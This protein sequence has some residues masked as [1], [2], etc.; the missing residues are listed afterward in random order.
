MQ[1]SFADCVQSWA[2]TWYHNILGP[3]LNALPGPLTP[4]QK[5]EHATKELRRKKDLIEELERERQKR[6]DDSRLIQMQIKA[7][8]AYVQMLNAGHPDA[9]ET[10]LRMNSTTIAQ[11][12]GDINTINSYIH[13]RNVRADELQ[14][15]MNE[16][17]KRM[18]ECS[19]RK[20]ALEAQLKKLNTG[21]KEKVL[22][23]RRYSP[24][25]KILKRTWKSEEAIEAALKDL[26]KNDLYF[27]SA[28]SGTINVSKYTGSIADMAVIQKG[29]RLIPAD[30]VERD[31]FIKT[32][33][34]G[35]YAAVVEGHGFTIDRE[36]RYV[37]NGHKIGYGFTL[38]FKE[39]QPLPWIKITFSIPNSAYNAVAIEDLESEIESYDETLR[40]LIS[41]NVASGLNKTKLEEGIQ[42]LQEKK[43]N[44]ENEI[45]LINSTPIEQQMMKWKQDLQK[46]IQEKRDKE[47]QLQ[48]FR[49]LD[50][51]IERLKAENTEEKKKLKMHQNDQRNLAII[52]ATHWESA[53]LLRKF[54]KIVLA[55]ENSYPGNGEAIKRCREFIE[56][57]DTHESSLLRQIKTEYGF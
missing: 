30:E 39:R 7:Q 24:N 45:A 15:A 31:R 47:T 57:F 9:A 22:F 48:D 49:E 1:N 14:C 51:Q 41:Y 53:R 43:A 40:G 20:E 18:V 21:T 16:N 25:E 52:I 11:K 55:P 23:E 50:Q 8:E 6:I 13:V 27:D 44:L 12:T 42:F 26:S 37:E 34:G 32:R 2:H 3:F 35:G 29:Y 10:L 56:L 4:V 19:L 54:V 36:C 17:E 33:V 5:I 46:W 38:E 28:K